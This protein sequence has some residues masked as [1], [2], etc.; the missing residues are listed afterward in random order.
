L[1]WIPG[2][3]EGGLVSRKMPGGGR[4]RSGCVKKKLKLGS[5]R[6]GKRGSTV[7]LVKYMPRR[8]PR[9]GRRNFVKKK[10]LGN[11]KKRIVKESTKGG[12]GENREE[13]ASP[14]V[15]KISFTG[16]GKVEGP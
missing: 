5:P 7:N 6:K 12:S 1:G 16:K 2:A 10:S 4:N 15:G 13:R 3:S 14:K 11:G 9:Q 8:G